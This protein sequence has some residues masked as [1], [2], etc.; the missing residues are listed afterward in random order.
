MRTT[1]LIALMFVLVLTGCK[2][3]PRPPTSPKA[4]DPVVAAVQGVNRAVKRS[5]TLQEMHD[6]HLTI[7]QAYGEMGMM[8]TKEFVLDLEKKEN[9]KLYTMLQD[10]LIVLTGTKVHESV[11]AYE[12]DAPTAGGYILSHNGPERLMSAEEVKLRL[13]NQ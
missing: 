4:E 11:W 12:K 7:E 10:G 3:G 5:V 8:P 13:A 9:R 2:R 6:L 1:T